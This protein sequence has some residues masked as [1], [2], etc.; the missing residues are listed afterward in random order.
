MVIWAA[1]VGAF[2]GWLWSDFEDYGVLLGG[3]CGALAGLGLRTAV[4]AEVSR[5]IE[6]WHAGVPS[7]SPRPLAEA[8]EFLPPSDPPVVPRPAVARI[9][10]QAAPAMPPAPEAGDVAPASSEPSPIQRLVSAAKDWLMGGNTVVRLGLA[11][12]FVGLTFL[13]RY[14]AAAGL[15]P[16]ELRLAA[17]ALTGVALLAFGFRSRIARPMFG[18]SLQGAGVAVVYLTLF[19]AVKLVSDF[20][21]LAAFAMMILVCALGCALAL[22]QSSQ[23][24]ALTAFAGGY[25]T[26][27]LLSDGAGQVAGLFAY[28]SILNLAVLY[29]ASRR[30]WRLLNLLGFFATFGVATLWMAGGYRPTDFW[31][32]QAFVAASV[33]I[34][35]AAAVLFA[36]RTPGRI[37]A[38]VD[39][40][41]LFG[42]ALA[43]FGLEVA[44]VGDRPFGA[45]FAAVAFAA[46]YL[47]VAIVVTRRDA[48]RFRVLHDAMLAIGVGF[49][50]LAV[51]LALGA[52]WTSAAWALEGAG[53]FW[54]GMRQARWAPRL[55]GLLLIGVA[56]LIFLS[57]TQGN[58]AMLPIA[59]ATFVGA[60]LIAGAMLATAWWLREP[61]PQT[62][63]WLARRYISIER[64]LG[65]PLFLAGF[66]FWWLA[67]IME[68]QRRLPPF[69]NDDVAKPVFDPAMALL[70]PMLAFVLS[71]WGARTLGRRTDW[72]VA[73]WPSFTTL[74]V[75]GAFF[76]GALAQGSHLALAPDW[77]LWV[78]AIAVHLWLL[79]ANDRDF[80]SPGVRVLLTGIHVGGVWLATAMLADCLWLAVDRARL[81]N[82]S[83]AGVVF[84]ASVTAVLI[85]LTLW[86]GPA[87]RR[88]G[89][90]WPLDRHAVAYGWIAA[91]PVAALGFVGALLTAL[92]ASGET[93][94]LPYLPLLNPV[95]L[96]VALAIAAL[97]IWRRAVLAA[98]PLP[99]GAAALRGP[100]VG[101]AMGLLMFVAVTTVWLRVAHRWL[102]VPWT[103]D[104]LLADFAVQTGLAILWTL[105]ALVLMVWAHRK[106]QRLPWLVG[107][108]LLGLTVVKLLLV[109]MTNSGGGARIVAFIGVGALMLVVGYLAPLPP[110][111]AAKEG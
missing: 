51:P 80:D 72:A 106:G 66:G 107:A 101:A 23:A 48:E 24:L 18:L 57:E 45:A 103:A 85:A 87:L 42:P 90:H 110:R 2:I 67:W 92:I 99:V 73:S 108:G 74:S 86:A 68:A 88:G 3:I 81:W 26:P 39:T 82:T 41:L 7:I 96:C 30:A 1:L 6:A 27:M 78:A 13:I 55:F 46:L 34:Y 59:N 94:P 36:R 70:L 43:G 15:F 17:V 37:G 32:T 50:T 19:A 102:G 60:M 75:L 9:I 5:T 65:A 47:A 4:R 31:V 10:R 35:L 12:L 100:T 64:A 89:R 40:T 95:D 71:A 28:Y 21:V 91:A 20:P 62:G 58:V 105:I 56:A 53:A 98:D 11:I 83:W 44:L 29:I 52:R 54:V 33:L 8:P 77:I 104:A 76:V 25:A 49:V 16:I 14:A 63:S 109:D 38:V 69:T 79:R 97:L 93:A 111:R 61:T 84:S 22:S